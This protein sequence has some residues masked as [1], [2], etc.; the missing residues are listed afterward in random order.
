MICKYRIYSLGGR[1]VGQPVSGDSFRGPL[2]RLPNQDHGLF[3]FSISHNKIMQKRFCPPE[4]L[5]P[6]VRP[7]HLLHGLRRPH[8]NCLFVTPNQPIRISIRVV[9]GL[10]RALSSSLSLCGSNP[11]PFHSLMRILGHH[12]PQDAETIWGGMFYS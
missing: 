5:T 3:S 9:G 2:S 1:W 6:S 8:P 11:F 7:S 12:R 10:F 4:P